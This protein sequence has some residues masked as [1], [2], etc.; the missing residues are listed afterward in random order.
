MF[1]P[2]LPDTEQDWLTD[3]VSPASSRPQERKEYGAR[4]GSQPAH[5]PRYAAALVA[6]ISAHPASVN[7]FGIAG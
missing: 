5:H 2:N 3:G 4:C 7:S 1:V 6:L